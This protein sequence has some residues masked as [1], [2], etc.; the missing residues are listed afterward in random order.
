MH[1]MHF[2]SSYKKQKYL[3]FPYYIL[4]ITLAQH[5]KRKHEIMI[6]TVSLIQN[7]VPFLLHATSIKCDNKHLQLPI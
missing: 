1:L 5:H 6:Y 3:K 7:C 2:S 4:K